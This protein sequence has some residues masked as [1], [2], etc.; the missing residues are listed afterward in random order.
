VLINDLGDALLSDF[1][2]SRIR[3]D[4][5][6]RTVTAR[7]TAQEDPAIGS[8]YWLSPERFDGG[9]PKE[10]ADIYALGVTIYEVRLQMLGHLLPIMLIVG[11]V[12]DLYW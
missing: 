3:D 12:L 5:T 1:G 6:S 11:D 8:I 7:P 2:L 4:M 10:P 9:R